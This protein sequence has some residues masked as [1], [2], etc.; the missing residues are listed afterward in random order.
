LEDVSDYRDLNKI[1]I[2]DKF[3][4]PNIDELLDELHGVA[5]FTK[6]DLKSGYHQIRL[7]KYDIPKTILELMM[8]TM[9]SW[10]CLL[11]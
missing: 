6:L 11:G 7:R 5:Y 1:T 8:G 4:I 10:S 3:P 2:K 9:S